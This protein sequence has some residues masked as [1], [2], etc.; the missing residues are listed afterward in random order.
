MGRVDLNIDLGELEGEDE[1]LYALA[2][3]ANVA[4]GGHAGDEATMQRA[5][6]LARRHRTRVA[7]HPSF[8]DRAHFGRLLIEV[9]PAELYQA[10]VDQVSALGAVVRAAGMDLFG[11][12]PH[13]ALYHAAAAT[14]VTAAALLDAAVAAWPAPLVVVGPSYGVL[15]EES[16]R[17]ALAYAREGFADRGYDAA[18]KL[19]PRGEPG[20]LIEEPMQCAEQ[21]VRLAR[22]GAADTICVHGDG[23]RALETAR[24][25]RDRLE[26]EGLL[27]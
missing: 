22:S 23:P 4:C 18:G 25:V 26:R 7:A 14:P 2:T 16:R 10:I 6:D 9:E 24:A 3:V 20:A 12:K 17:R 27:R 5:V 19:I 1:E 8:A 21:A 13:G 11:V 15:A